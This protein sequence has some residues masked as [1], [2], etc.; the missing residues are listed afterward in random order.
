MSCCC[1]ICEIP[2]F[3]TATNFYALWFT[4]TA[5]HDLYDHIQNHTDIHGC[6]RGKY[7]LHSY[8]YVNTRQ[9]DIS[10][11]FIVIRTLLFYMINM[12]N[13]DPYWR[14]CLGGLTYQLA[15]I[16]SSVSFS[17]FILIYNLISARHSCIFWIAQLYF[18]GLKFGCSWMSSAYIC[19]STPCFRARG[20]SGELYA[21]K[22]NGPIRDKSCSQRFGCWHGTIDDDWLRSAR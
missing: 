6:W 19:I 20:M 16:G 11:V 15:W 18:S 7:L 2:Y 17:K 8:L 22:V 21:G 12:I 1:F 10:I 9:D 4:N 13:T 3:T 14:A 5:D